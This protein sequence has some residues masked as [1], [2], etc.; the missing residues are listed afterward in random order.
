MSISD[1][2]VDLDNMKKSVNYV[3]EEILDKM[4]EKE[5]IFFASS[6][7]QYIDLRLLNK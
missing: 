4:N 3:K 2:V 1:Q 7:R 5:L 6:I